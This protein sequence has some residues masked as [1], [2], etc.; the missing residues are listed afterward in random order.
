MQKETQIR[1]ICSST[2]S[3]F[4]SVP[5]PFDD[6]QIK[7]EISNLNEIKKIKIKKN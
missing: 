6:I 2:R 7:N 3:F 5:Q 1:E 4:I